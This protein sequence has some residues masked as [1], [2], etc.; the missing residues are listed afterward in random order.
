MFLYR[1]IRTSGI[2]FTLAYENRF[3]DDGSYIRYA[4]ITPFGHKNPKNIRAFPR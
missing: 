1:Y 3:P 2:D 4:Y